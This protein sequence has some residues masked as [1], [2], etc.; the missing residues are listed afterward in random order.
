MRNLWAV[1]VAAVA[2]ALAWLILTTAPD[3]E[4][5]ERERGVPWRHAECVSRLGW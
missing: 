1:F 4:G 2:M 3:P 5:C